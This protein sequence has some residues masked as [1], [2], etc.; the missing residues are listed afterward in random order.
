MVDTSD[1]WIIKRT[2]IAQRRLLEDDVPAYT[3]AVEA[4]KLSLSNS[5]LEASDIDLI[6]VS[7]STPDYLTPTTSC[8]IQRELGAK[9]AAAFDLGAA[10]TGFLYAITVAKQFVETGYYKRVMVVSCEAMSK[11]VDYTDRNT[12]VLFG[13]GAGAVIIGEVEEG[14]GIL[15]TYMASDG[16]DGTNITIPCLYMPEFDLERRKN[17]IKKNTIWQD[18]SEVFK[19][20]VRI[21]PVAIEKVIENTGLEVKDL[22]YIIP[23][24]ANIRIIEG[25]AKRLQ[26][27]MDKVY[28][29]IERYGNISSASIPVALDDACRQK[30]IN[31]GDS[32][33]LVGFGG[34]LTWGSAL[35][36]WSC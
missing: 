18:G 6:I 33:V 27:S 24:Q 34:G 14:L 32:I 19:F 11:V 20:A 29:T 9:N 4:A 25:A 15:S 30:C 8:I 28:T 1:E 17:Y 16:T 3:M 35:L 26:I 22:K 36:K 5:G 23:H 12:C 10:C 7:T 21:M 31:K 2:G 13:D